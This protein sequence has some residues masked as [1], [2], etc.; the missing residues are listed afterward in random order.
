LFK[1][2]PQPNIT[3]VG[4]P[5]KRLPSNMS[6]GGTAVK[7]NVVDPFVKF[8]TNDPQTQKVLASTQDH[9]DIYDIRDDVILLKNGDV[10]LVVETTAV[11]FQLLSNYEQDLKLQAFSELINSLNFELQI[12]IHTEPI[13][14]RKYLAYLDQNYRK[15]Q[16][17][18]LRKQMEIY[19]GFVKDLVVQN[20]VLQKRFFVVIPHRSGKIT[21][22]Q[23]NPFQKVVDVIAGR[24]RVIELKDADKLIEKALLQ[25]TP[26][27]DHLMKMLSRM[28]LGSKQMNN[29]ELT[30][31]FYSYYNPVDHF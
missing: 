7:E 23:V 17:D 19:M 21:A 8:F 20:N 27:R 3:G 28:G 2:K 1:K 30:Q 16:R 11:N 25:L 18:L 6:K 5:N 22:D 12:V 29:K 26:K 15:I 9:L 13:D 14:M 4:I 10:S 24:K 31:L